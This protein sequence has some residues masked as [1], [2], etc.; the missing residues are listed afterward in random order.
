M[1]IEEVE[2]FIK[3]SCRLDNLYDDFKELSKKYG[4]KVVSKYSI[5]NVN[6]V[7]GECN[8]LLKSMQNLHEDIK[9]IDEDELPTNIDILIMLNQIR[10]KIEGIRVLN[11]RHASGRWEW[12]VDGGKKVLY[13]HPPKSIKK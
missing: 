12:L 4:D 8:D 11:I 2:K 13:T 7:I 1:K 10:A 5:K 9:N 6:D 3:A